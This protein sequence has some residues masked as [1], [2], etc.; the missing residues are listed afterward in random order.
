MSEML[1]MYGWQEAPGVRVETTPFGAL[2]K[3][4]LAEEALQ[5][6]PEALGELIVELAYGARSNSKFRGFTN[7]AVV[8]GDHYASYI[9]ERCGVKLT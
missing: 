3:L 4:D 9:A 8:L 6:S 5:L 1:M 7:L 2:K